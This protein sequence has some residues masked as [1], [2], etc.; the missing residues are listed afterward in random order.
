MTRS[1][2]RFTALYA[3]LASAG[4]SGAVVATALLWGSAPAGEPVPGTLVAGTQRAESEDVTAWLTRAQAALSTRKYLLDVPGSSLEVTAAQLGIELDVAE[5]RRALLTRAAQG[6]QLERLSRKWRARHG[7]ESVPPRMRMNAPRARSFL[8]D[9]APGL[10]Q[11]ATDARVDLEHH[12]KIPD[13]S[14]R[15]LDIEASV[16]SITALAGGDGSRVALAFREIPAAVTVDS[17]T[18]VDVSQVLA[19]F[20]TDF[21]GKAGQRKINI[22]RAAKYLDGTVVEPGAVLSFNRAVGARSAERG[23]V[24]APVIVE[25]VM[26]PGLGGGVCQVASTLFAASVHGNLEVVRR[27]SHSRPTGYTPLGLDAAVIEDELDL[28]LKNPY[29]VPLLVHAYLPTETTIR[30][31]LLGHRIRDKVEHKY[32]VEERHD[33]ER[34]VKFTDAVKEPKRKQKGNYGYDVVSVVSTTPADGKVQRR[35]YKST[36]YPVPEVYWVPLAF[37]LTKLPE[38]PEGATQT[39]VVEETPLEEMP[40]GETVPASEREHATERFVAEEPELAP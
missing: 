37:D 10:A 29:S 20:E 28:R 36:Y 1:A 2:T 21:K 14:G 31:E 22:E 16:A 15:E 35:T 27:R 23:F 18:P 9:L 32:G 24:S 34:R 8:K 17:L 5:T 30:V 4:L 26:E 38:L 19:V 12:A 7:Q 33:F 40:V 13:V 39:V 11:E 3:V 25:D 6:N